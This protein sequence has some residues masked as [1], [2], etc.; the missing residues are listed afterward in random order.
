[1]NSLDLGQLFFFL[2]LEFFFVP[3]GQIRFI[4]QGGGDSGDLDDYSDN[5]FVATV[6]PPKGESSFNF[7]DIF[8]M[9]L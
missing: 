3:S 8:T 7:F 6:R 9:S 4:N 1:M 2:K 5:E